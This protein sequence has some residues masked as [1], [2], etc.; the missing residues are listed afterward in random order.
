[1]AYCSLAIHGGWWI[2]TG[3]IAF[4]PNNGICSFNAGWI[5]SIFVFTST[6]VIVLF[7][8]LWLILIKR[9]GNNVDGEREEGPGS[10]VD[11]FM[12]DVRDSYKFDGEG[13]QGVRG[14]EGGER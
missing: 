10:D 14:G 12:R 4:I 9:C 3:F 2:A 11:F 5:P 8:S 1:M 13:Y 6:F 7:V